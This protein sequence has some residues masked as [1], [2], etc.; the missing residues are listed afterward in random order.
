LERAGEETGRSLPGLRT[1]AF[2][3]GPEEL[4]PRDP[5]PLRTPMPAPGTPMRALRDPMLGVTADSQA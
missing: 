3:S 2:R 1:R 5:C 4:R